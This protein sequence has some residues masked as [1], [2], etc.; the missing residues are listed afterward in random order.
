VIEF[1]C[2][3]GDPETQAI[4][5]LLESPLDE[6]MLACVERRLHKIPPI[7]WKSGASV[8][9]VMAADGYPEKSRM[10]EFITG[11]GK[12]EEAGALVFHAGTKLQNNSLVTA[13]GRVLGVTA[14]GDT[15]EDAIARVY[16]AVGHVDGGDLIYRRDIGWRAVST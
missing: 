14:T 4:L 10:G 11:I 15:I 7:A 13:G 1:N 16:E 12:A 8:C 9:V 6:L 2:R 5:P 3:F